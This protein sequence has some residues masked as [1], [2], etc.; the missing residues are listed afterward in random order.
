M[1]NAHVL[2]TDVCE[3]DALKSGPQLCMMDVAIHKTE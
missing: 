1:A 3:K 2:G